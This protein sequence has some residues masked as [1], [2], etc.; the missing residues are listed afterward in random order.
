[1]VERADNQQR[2]HRAHL[3]LLDAGQDIHLCLG[4]QDSRQK[5]SGNQSPVHHGRQQPPAHGCQFQGRGRLDGFG[6]GLR[7]LDRFSI[8][9]DAGPHGNQPLCF[10][11][12][13]R[14][15]CHRGLG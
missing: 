6:F 4:H 9:L 15:S 7:V 5:H 3:D 12:L 13:S 2:R 10:G 11:R 8:Q 1:M 14:W